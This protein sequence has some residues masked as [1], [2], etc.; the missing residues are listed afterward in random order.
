M[1]HQNALLFGILVHTFISP[2]PA[3]V[4]TNPAVTGERSVSATACRELSFNGRINGDEEYSRELGDKLWVQF[5]PTKD[6]WGWI[7]SIGPADGTD[8]YASPVNPPLR[9]DNSQY[10]STGYGDTVEYR[11]KNEHRIF[12]VFDRANYDRALKLV[13]D[14]AFSKNADG[15]SRYRAALPT[16]PTGILYLKPIRFEAVNEGK[17]VN[18]MEYSLTVIVPASFEPAAGLSPKQRPCPP[19]H[20]S[21]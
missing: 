3:H 10:L 1:C 2:A 18:W 16:I 15:A 12:F 6:K 20:W 11:L 5:A 19:M 21:P 14:E 7:V 9:G 13:N 4:Q 17:S 8:D